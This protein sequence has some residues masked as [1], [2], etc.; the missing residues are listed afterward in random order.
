M[1]R[2]DALVC[3]FV[4]AFVC[5]CFVA[6]S[7]VSSVLRPGLRFWKVALGCHIRLVR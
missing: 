1:K 7:R 4:S 6:C 5:S 2:Y 3:A